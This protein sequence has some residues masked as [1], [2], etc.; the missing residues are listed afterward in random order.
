[1]TTPKLQTSDAAVNFR[2]VIASGA[3]QRTGIFPPFVV[4]SCSTDPSTPRLNPKSAILHS[5][6][7]ST[8]TFRAAKS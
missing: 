1:M 3:V 7:E 5:K 8:N 2:C 6:F 4:Y